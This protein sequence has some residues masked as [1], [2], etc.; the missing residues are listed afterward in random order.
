MAVS[1]RS[2]KTA[3][4]PVVGRFA[5]VLGANIRARRIALS[6]AQG[7]LADLIGVSQNNLS[8]LELGNQW[9][10]EDTLISICEK[11]DVKPNELM[12]PNY[13]ADSA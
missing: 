1:K 2:R 11:L 10:R 6:I 13:F 7:D 5:P 8:Q 12:T 9:I 3:A 4:R